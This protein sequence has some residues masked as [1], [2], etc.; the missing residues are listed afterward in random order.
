M[1]NIFWQLVCLVLSGW[2]GGCTAN[3]VLTVIPLKSLR[4]LHLHPHC[5]AVLCKAGCKYFL[6][7]NCKCL[8]K[9][10]IAFAGHRLQPG[11]K[12]AQALLKLKIEGNGPQ[13]L[14]SLVKIVRMRLPSKNASWQF[15]PPVHC[16]VWGPCCLHQV[17][18]V[19]YCLLL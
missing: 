19:Q 18:V 13:K 15:W 5:C 12:H 14:L 16:R 4:Y 11:T 2:V 10:S 3:V 1:K 17:T 7:T 8:H 9:T 6:A